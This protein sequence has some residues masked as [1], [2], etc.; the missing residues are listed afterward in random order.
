M[1]PV[2]VDDLMAICRRRRHHAAEVHMV[3]AE[4]PGRI[5]VHSDLITDVVAGF[6]VAPIEPAG[7]L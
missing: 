7:R 5:L 6:D 1:F 4:A 2:S 3:R